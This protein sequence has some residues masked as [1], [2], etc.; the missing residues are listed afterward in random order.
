[1]LIVA[2]ILSAII[3]ISL[4]SYI[5][6]CTNSLRQA[7]RSFHAYSANNLAEMGLEEALY[8]FNQL[9]NG[10]VAAA[11]PAATWTTYDTTGKRRKWTNID[12]GQGAT[13]SVHVYAKY[14][15]GTN[16][17]PLIVAKGT[18]VTGPNEPPVV[19]YVE[20]Y[21][22]KRGLFTNGLVARDTISWVG[23]PNADSWNSD[24]DNNPATP[25]VPYPGSGQT[26]ECSVGCI[27]GSIGLGAG[28]NV[29]G[30]AKT[31]PNGTITGGSVHGLGT[32][33]DDPSRKSNDFVATL[34]PIGMP[35]PTAG[36]YH[37]GGSYPA[38]PTTFPAAGHTT[39]NPSDNRFYYIF[40]GG[41]AISSKANTTITDHVTMFFPDPDYRGSDTINLAGKKTISIA[42]TGASL[43]VY[44]AGN[45]DVTGNAMTNNSNVPSKCIIYG[46]SASATPQTI[47][48]GGN[49]QLAAAIYAPNAAV[50]MRGGGSSGQVSGSVVAKTIDMNGG[51]DFHYDSALGNL[52]SGNPFGVA[53]WRELQTEAERTP[54]VSILNF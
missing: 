5:N 42:A 45:I 34:P 20:V 40:H 22:R 39:R 30:W 43:I 27:N 38:V 31:G 3:G 4:V 36:I 37:V 12:L 18:V 52:T 25:A 14:F 8:C 7:N 53:R 44:T 48:V 9:D 10:T 32:T 6:V 17:S 26:A 16:S 41:D 15:D 51:T 33:T 1:V 50:E 24:P 49:G 13:G 21:L 47:K 19:K 11:W 29:Y 54:F 35:I 28:G 46:I 2:M 23:H